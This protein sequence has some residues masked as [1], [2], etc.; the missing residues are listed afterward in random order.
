MWKCEKKYEN[1]I[2]MEMWKI[3]RQANPESKRLCRYENQINQ[4]IAL[5]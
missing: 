5:I 3:D 1:V 4:I 2:N